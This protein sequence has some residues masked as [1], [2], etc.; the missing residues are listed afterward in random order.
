MLKFSKILLAFTWA[1]L[2]F[3]LLTKSMSG[4]VYSVTFTD[5]I[6][7]FFLFGIFNFLLIEAFLNKQK[8]NFYLAAVLA[9]VLTLIYS[10]F[11][12]YLQRFFP[13]RFEDL[14]DFTAGAFGALGFA[15]LS[16]IKYR[17]S[18]PKLLLHICCAGCGV[19]VSKEMSKQ[20]N[21]T[22]YFCNPNIWPEKEFDIRRTEVKKIAKE[23]GLKYI[24][25]EYDHA[26]W[27]K[28]VKGHEKDPEKGERCLICYKYRLEQSA[29]FAQAK[30]FDYFTTTLTIS[31]H[32]DAKAIFEIGNKLAKKYKVNFLEKDFKKQDGFKKSVVMSQALGLYRQNYCGCEFSR[33]DK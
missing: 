12:E 13:G 15:I 6:A 25:D 32:K 9:V 3:A 5:K 27:L 24:I 16:Y 20:Y 30:K 10:Y 29:K 18:L 11:M 4:N 14:L 1:V 33:R 17:K 28:L 19:Y 23:Y 31:P 21:I 8:N 22:L 2:I 7:H 26:K